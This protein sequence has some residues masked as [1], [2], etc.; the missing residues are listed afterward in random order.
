MGTLAH[1]H[2]IGPVVGACSQSFGNLARHD[3]HPRWHC[4]QQLVQ[5]ELQQWHSGLPVQDAAPSMQGLFAADRGWRATV[6]YQQRDI[7][8]V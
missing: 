3:W 2:L 7:I 6:N 1:S 4:G 8:R 5:R